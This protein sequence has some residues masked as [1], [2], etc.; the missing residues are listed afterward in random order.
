MVKMAI[1]YKI[2]GEIERLAK[3]NASGCTSKYRSDQRAARYGGRGGVLDELN[4]VR[5]N[6]AAGVDKKLSD[7]W[8]KY[9]NARG[10]NTNRADQAKHDFTVVGTYP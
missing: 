10:A 5:T 9:G 2:Q 4:F 1:F 6:S 7:G 8:V 3:K